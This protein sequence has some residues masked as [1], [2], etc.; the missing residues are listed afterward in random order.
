MKYFLSQIIIF[1]LSVIFLLYL[2]SLDYFL[3]FDAGEN[4]NW[5]NISI[6]LFLLFLSLQSVISLG[7]YFLQKFLA[8]GW[9]EFPD[10]RNSF[11]WGIGLGISIVVLILF[12]ALDLLIIQWALIVLVLVVVALTIM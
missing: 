2:F 3:P 4:L 6:V 11:K 1:I 7:V 8:Y 10:F 12:N 5:Y 9:K